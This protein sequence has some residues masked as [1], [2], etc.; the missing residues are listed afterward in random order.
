MGSDIVDSWPFLLG[1]VVPA[2]DN[3]VSSEEPLDDLLWHGMMRLYQQERLA[4]VPD[5]LDLYSLTVRT[6]RDAEREVSQCPQ[7]T[8]NLTTMNSKPAQREE[9]YLAPMDASRA[10]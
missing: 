8:L 4:P 5:W 1:S 10:L 7:I 9:S 3:G 2:Y 6:V